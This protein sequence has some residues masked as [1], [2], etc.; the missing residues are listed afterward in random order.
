MKLAWPGIRALLLVAGTA[1]SAC[2]QV[3]PQ[4]KPIAPKNASSAK[5]TAADVAFMQ[6]MIGHHAQAIEMCAMAGSHGASAQVAL[7]CKKV[8]ISQRDE[9]AL[10][11]NWLKVRGEMVPDP[12][13]PHAHHMMP[14][15]QMVGDTLMPGMMTPEQ[16]K[17]L[18]AARGTE[19]D[20]LFL[21]GMIQHHG[22]AIT[23]VQALFDSPGSGQDTEVFGFATGVDNDQRAEIERMQQMLKSIP[24]GTQ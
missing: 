7:F 1:L 19:W 5:Y 21:Q 9:I 14:G 4:E 17:A 6:G 18:D 15:M 24:G 13:N 10:M 3:T 16:M 8:T 20:R 2:A 23:M 22:G 11:S 12:A